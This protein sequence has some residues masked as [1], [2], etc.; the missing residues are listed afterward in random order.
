MNVD[1]SNL[2]TDETILV[3]IGMRIKRHRLDRQLTQ[4]E[5]AEQTGGVEAHRRADRDRGLGAVTDHYLAAGGSGSS[6]RA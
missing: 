1:I 6:A 5:M 4:A 3:E 2:L